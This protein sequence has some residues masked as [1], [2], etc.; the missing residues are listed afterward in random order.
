[1]STLTIAGLSALINSEECIFA[2]N[3][4]T[5]D[6]GQETNDQGKRIAFGEA[7]VVATIGDIEVTY[8]EEWSYNVGSKVFETQKSGDAISGVSIVDED[9]DDVD[10]GM[11]IWLNIDNGIFPVHKFKVDYSSIRDDS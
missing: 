5:F 8:F 4:E 2:Q 3:I 9:G 11:E 1:M 6:K 7:N 10:L